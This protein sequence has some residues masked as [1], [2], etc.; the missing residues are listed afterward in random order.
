MPSHPSLNHFDDTLA[1]MVMAYYQKSGVNSLYRAVNRLDK[2]TSGIVLAAKDKVISARLNEAMKR[3]EIKKTYAAILRGNIAEAYPDGG[4]IS[5]PIR[6]EAGSI[7]K[8]VCAP[9]GDPAETLFKVIKRG[10]NLSVAEVYPLTG[11]THQIRLHF[12]HIGYPLL[13]EDLYGEPGVLC[14]QI[15]RHAL[16]AQSL[17]LIHPG[18]NEK[19]FLKCELPGDMAGIINGI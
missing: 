8:R 4:R 19:I 2:N 6:R 5:V 10:E 16:H 15:G 18:N 11:R 9:D 7:I 14:A 3:G 13:G 1:N 17:E 12:C